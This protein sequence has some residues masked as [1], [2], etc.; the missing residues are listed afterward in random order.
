MRRRNCLMVSVFLVSILALSGMLFGQRV[1]DLDKVWGD[2]RVLGED[3][4]DQSG[5]AVA[6]GDINGDG[7]MDI[8]IGA[9]YADPPGGDNAGETYVIFGSS[10]P[11]STFDLN[12]ESADITVKGGDDAND[13]SGWA[14]AS[15]DVNG[16]GYDDLI[17]GANEANPPG[18]YNAGTTY[19]IFGSSNPPQTI[20]LNSQPADITVY[21]ADIYDMSGSAVASGDV[22]GDGYDDIIIGAPWANKLGGICAGAT[23]IVL[24][25]DFT[26][27]VVIDLSTDQADITVYGDDVYDNLGQAV[28]SGDINADSVDDIIIGASGANPPGGDHAGKNYV[29]FGNSFPSPPY[30]ID[31]DS[32]PADITI[33][34]DDAEDWSGWAVA[35]G[36][37]NGDG[38]DDI[39]IGAFFAD[40]SGGECAG[41]TYVIFGSSFTSPPYT[42]DLNSQSADITIYGDDAADDSGWAVAS[43]D[44]NADG[45]DD[46]LIG[47]PEAE[48]HGMIDVIDVG[49]TYVILGGGPITVAHGKG[50]GSWV[51][52]WDTITSTKIFNRI[53]FG[54]GNTQGEVHV[55]RSDVD[56]DEQEEL[57][58]GHGYGGSSWVSVYK[59]N[60]TRIF[61]QRVF[62]GGNTNGEVHVGAG[63][64]DGDGIDE[65]ICGHGRGGSSWVNV[66][67]LDGTLILTKKV[68]GSGNT[69][70]EVHVA[71][72]DVDGD[73]VDEIICGHGRGGSSWVKVYQLGGSVIFNRKV[74][75][76]GNTLG[77]VNV[78]A[79][80]VD[81]DIDDDIICGHGFGGNSWVKVLRF[82]GTVIFNKKVFG[83]GNANGEVHVAGGNIGLDRTD[84]ILCGQGFGGSSWVKIYQLDGTIL[85]IKQVFGGGN[86]NGE[87][88]VTCR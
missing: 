48:R 62:G 17:I 32:Q 19:V 41:E 11:P 64:V 60:G 68:F 42:I 22:N 24:G 43:G 55:A 85:Y 72:G 21:G 18:A 14:V 74:F 6:Y 49:E 39:I 50:G 73:G 46:L 87:V 27:P 16:D 5:S 58:C 67:R 75:G 71:G 38:Y 88:H 66:Y 63:D 82:N 28:S 47:A 59:L 30:T 44:V 80:N 26:T 12:T 40:P 2:M 1:V 69:Q 35:S 29:L 25:A 51:A 81:Y 56:G 78:A 13:Y 70:G 4:D 54:A 79:G 53:V 9:P 37:V 36:D 84:E 61:N 20:D 52:V 65:V 10:S 34:G 8:I 76:T 45:Y 31:L 86:T 15:G 23:Y 57:I 3:A 83:S 77:D 33:Y 7:Y